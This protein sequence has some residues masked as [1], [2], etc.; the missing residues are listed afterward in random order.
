[1]ATEPRR[2]QRSGIEIMSEAMAQVA[3]AVIRR[4]QRQGYVV[5]RDIRAEMKLAGLAEDDWKTVVEQAKASLNYRQ[6]RYYHVS[7]VSPRLHEE[8][9][10][11]Q[12]VSKLV[13]Q[14]IKRHREAAKERERRG[15]I[16]TDFVTPLKITTEDGKE[17]RLMSRDISA[18]GIRLLGTQRLLGQKVTVWLAA[19]EGEVPVGVATRILWTCAVGDGLYENGGNFLEAVNPA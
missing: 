4:A 17:H 6:G 1:M 3:E 8:Q 13:K 5:P 2:F 7:A 14:L 12:I 10:H 9:Q 15:Q 16:R 19:L 18:T 11:L